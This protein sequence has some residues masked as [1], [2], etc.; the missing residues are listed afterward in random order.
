MTFFAFLIGQKMIKVAIHAPAYLGTAH[1][2]DVE[3]QKN[4]LPPVREYRACEQQLW[5]ANIP[6]DFTSAKLNRLSAPARHGFQL[7]QT[8]QQYNFLLTNQPDTPKILMESCPA[9]CFHQLVNSFLVEEEPLLWRL[10]HQL[11]LHNHHLPVQDPMAFFEEITRY[12]LLL[13]K[14]SL[15]TILITEELNAMIIAYTAWLSHHHP[16]KSI[17]MGK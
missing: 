6:I 15:E 16:E 1:T 11:I 2:S 4:N 3:S 14:V 13:G 9:A 7:F 8:L 10:Q 17:H 12:K 5:Q